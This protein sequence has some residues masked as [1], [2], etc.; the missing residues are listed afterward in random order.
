MKLSSYKITMDF[1]GTITKKL[2]W[3]EEA[4]QI[5]V[6][7]DGHVRFYDVEF[8]SIYDC[9]KIYIPQQGEHLEIS[10]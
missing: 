7:P 5:Q 6:T 3:Y 2:N 4:V 9:K 1:Y 8:C 10:K